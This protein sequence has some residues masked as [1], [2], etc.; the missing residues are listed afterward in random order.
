MFPAKLIAWSSVLTVV[1]STVC[2]PPSSK[3]I[4]NSFVAASK[5][6]AVICWSSV[7]SKY[8]ERSTVPP[9]SKVRMSPAKLN[10]WSSAVSYTHLTLPTNR[11]V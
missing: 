3:V 5:L 2:V 7:L 4:V 11:E 10:A 1:K 6:N 8:G 9:S